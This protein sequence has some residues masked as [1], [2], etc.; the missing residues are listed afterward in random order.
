MATVE[1]HLAVVMMSSAG[2]KLVKDRLVECQIYNRVLVL[3]PLP[4]EL[5]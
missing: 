3:F 2:T 1:M 5:A 4:G